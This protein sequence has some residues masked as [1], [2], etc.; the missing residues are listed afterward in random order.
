[1]LTDEEQ[2]SLLAKATGNDPTSAA[3]LWTLILR[4]EIADSVAL[5]WLRHVAARIVT[6]VVNC[7][8]EHSSRRADGALR[9]VGL[10]GRVNRTRWLEQFAEFIEE[11]DPSWTNKAAAQAV[12]LVEEDPLDPTTPYDPNNAERVI[13]RTRAEIRKK[14]R[15]PPKE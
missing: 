12:P 2:Q 4:E 5:A 7:E 10:S 14:L 11:H 9:A 15:V 6:N 8:E 1:M 13:Q 3:I